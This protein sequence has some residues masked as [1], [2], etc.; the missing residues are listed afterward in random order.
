MTTSTARPAADL[1]AAAAAIARH[2]R[3]VPA[4]E[5]EAAV[6]LLS[7]WAL[8]ALEGGRITP[9]DAT[10]ILTKLWV[11]VTDAPPGPEL[12][13]DVHTLLEEGGWLHDEAI[14]EAPDR[15]H[16]RALAHAVLNA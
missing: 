8:D 2:Y 7:L 16:L 15:G 6:A 12:S 11:G 3:S 9:D 13:E 14:G 4:R 10:T 5:T 1:E